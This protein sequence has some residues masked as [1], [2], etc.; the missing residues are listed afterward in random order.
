MF[1]PTNE[2]FAKLGDT[3]DMVVADKNLLTDVL[4]FHAVDDVVSSDDLV[5]AGKVEM[6]NG[7][8]SRTVCEGK[9]IFQKGGSNPRNA[10]PEIIET[11]IATCQGYIHVVGMCDEAGWSAATKMSSTGP[12]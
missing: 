5:C 10:M 6:A 3:L 7:Q 12:F 11:D 4:L 2:A 1:A 9:K 8:D